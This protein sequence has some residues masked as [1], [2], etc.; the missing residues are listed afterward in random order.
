VLGIVGMTLVLFGAASDKIAL[1][2]QSI[3]LDRLGSHCPIFQS[4]DLELEA[5]TDKENKIK[6]I[7]ERLLTSLK[8]KEYYIVSFGNNA[9]IPDYLSDAR[10]GSA[11]T[12]TSVHFEIGSYLDYT[13]Q[14]G[15]PPFG[16]TQLRR[17]SGMD[18]DISDGAHSFQGIIQPTDDDDESFENSVVALH[19]GKDRN[20]NSI[21]GDEPTAFISGFFLE[22]ADR[23]ITDKNWT[24]I[25]PLR[26]L[27]KPL[28]HPNNM[29]AP[30]DRTTGTHWSEKLLN[31]YIPLDCRVHIIYPITA[32]ITIVSEDVETNE[33]TMLSDANIDFHTDLNPLYYRFLEKLRVTKKKDQ[34][35]IEPRLTTFPA[36]I[37]AKRP[38]EALSNTTI[39]IIAVAD[40]SY[41]DL[42]ERIVIEKT[43]DQSLEEL[44]NLVDSFYRYTFAT[45]GLKLDLRLMQAWDHDLNNLDGASVHVDAYSQLCQFAQ[46]IPN[47]SGVS[48]HERMEGSN[49]TFLTHLFTGNDLGPLPGGKV[50]IDTGD[51][52]CPGSGCGSNGQDIIGISEGIAGFRNFNPEA[53]ACQVPLDLLVGELDETTDEPYDYLHSPAPFFPASFHSLSQ[54]VP[55]L[56]PK[57]SKID[58]V[59]VALEP[60][61]VTEPLNEEP[62]NRN[63]N[64]LLYQRFLLMAHEIGHNLGGIHPAIT[65]ESVGV[66]AAPAE[67][68][69]IMHARLDGNIQFRLD[70]NSK[71]EILCQLL[72][73]DTC[74]GGAP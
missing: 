71:L 53:R 36:G 62:L 2:T 17:N 21:P 3:A 52:F 64:A 1:S 69:T 19:I 72:G 27:L 10:S 9:T 59:L 56:P 66:G 11:T 73:S 44:V 13:V 38:E 35:S 5:L 51:G 70:E 4:L 41:Y 24:F 50:I 23:G 49:G 12:T 54:Q 65:F 29:F 57:P 74:T 40:R 55:D 32:E 31:S 60:D 46:N 20:I 16:E 42:Y 61:V 37:P 7:V 30:F 22:D 6:K 15:E 45:E 8:D 48:E 63:Y 39:P 58:P 33:I 34:G 68:S 47:A 67:L 28:V 26:P 14:F 43:W 18:E 25:E